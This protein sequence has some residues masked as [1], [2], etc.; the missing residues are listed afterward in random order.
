[1]RAPLQGRHR[2]LLRKVSRGKHRVALTSPFRGRSA[3]KES[4]MRVCRIVLLAFAA[5]LAVS[6]V[7]AQP[8]TNPVVV[9]VSLTGTGAQ[10]TNLSQALGSINDASATKPY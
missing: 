8:V 5:L 4:S 10:F 2:V 7:W 1:M 3:R 9:T 6:S